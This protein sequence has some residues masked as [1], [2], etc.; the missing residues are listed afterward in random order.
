MDADTRVPMSFHADGAPGY[1]AKRAVA[2]C[3]LPAVAFAIGLLLF[4]RDRT[5]G[6]TGD[7]V[8]ILF[9]VRA[10]FAALFPLAHLRWL[11]AAMTQLEAEGA[12]KP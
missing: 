3:A 1:R 12:L 5:V 11:K 7:L 6:M 2:L 8:L 4:V 9:G 10:T